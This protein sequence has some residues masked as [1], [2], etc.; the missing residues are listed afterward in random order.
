MGR[1]LIALFLVSFAFAEEFDYRVLDASGKPER[2]RLFLGE[3]WIAINHA[4]AVVGLNINEDE[5]YIE[6]AALRKSGKGLVEIAPLG[7]SDSR[8][9]SFEIVDRTKPDAFRWI[10]EDIAPDAPPALSDPPYGTLTAENG[11]VA[12]SGE[13]KGVFF[14]AYASKDNRLVK[15]Q[16]AVTERGL[17]ALDAALETREGERTRLSFSSAFKFDPLIALA[18]TKGRAYIDDKGLTFIANEEAEGNDLIVFIPFKGAEP[19]TI[20]VKIVKR[21]FEFIEADKTMKAPRSQTIDGVFRT[22]N[23]LAGGGFSVELRDTQSRLLLALF[24]PPSAKLTRSEGGGYAA[25]GEGIAIFVENNASARVEVGKS[26]ILIESPSVIAMLSGGAIEA[27]T[28]RGLLYAD[29]YG[30]RLADGDAAYPFLPDG[31]EARLNAEGFFAK[32]ILLSEDRFLP[33]GWIYGEDAEG[34]LSRLTIIDENEALLRAKWGGEAAVEYGGESFVAS[35][36]RSRKVTIFLRSGWNP[37]VPSGD[38]TLDQLVGVTKAIETAE[39]DRAALWAQYDSRLN[40]SLNRLHRLRAGQLYQLYAA[41]EGAIDLVVSPQSPIWLTNSRYVGVSENENAPLTLPEGF[42]I[43]DFGG[44]EAQ[45][46]QAGE[47]YRLVRAK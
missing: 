16:I 36:I 7:V 10:I 30:V 46:Y 31:S 39:T 47:F 9:I 32:A 6:V 17:I 3:K 11:F 23:T 38:L 24:A 40:R 20:A 21:S 13:P 35:P 14:A 15:K 5:N 26:R 12:Y 8:Y 29:R 37:F 19:I 41:R 4:P 18:P 33:F 45:N 44:F 28:G 34:E 43:I 1:L 2:I 27:K 22:I 25:I 42:R